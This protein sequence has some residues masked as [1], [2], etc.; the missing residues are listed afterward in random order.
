MTLQERRNELDRRRREVTA[1][2]SSMVASLRM[3][4]SQREQLIGAIS[5]LDQLIGEESQPKPN[6]A[7]SAADA[8]AMEALAAGG[9]PDA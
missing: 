7:M 9:E 2:E 8:V 5:V 1:A 3:L 4:R 6:G